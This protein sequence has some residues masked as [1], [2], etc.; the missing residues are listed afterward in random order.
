MPIFFVTS[1]EVLPRGQILKTAVAV[2][3]IVNAHIAG[4]PR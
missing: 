2:N 3:V 1:Y 4:I